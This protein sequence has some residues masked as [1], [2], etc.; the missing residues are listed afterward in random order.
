MTPGAG[1]GDWRIVEDDLSGAAIRA[2]LEQHFAGMLASSPAGSCHFLDF[3]GLN[4]DDVTFWSIHD[5]D[6]LAGCGALKMLDAAHGEIKSMRTADAFLR[7]G[8]AAHMLD[9]IIAE[10]HGRGLK[11]LSLETG[12]GAAFEPAIALYRRYDF[13]DC[14]PFADYK[15]DPFSR[16]MTRML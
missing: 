13:D 4:A 3:D 6:A 8:V 1:D 15:P 11:R 14:A 10:A 9:H 7:R 5:G 2:L 16:F 12:S